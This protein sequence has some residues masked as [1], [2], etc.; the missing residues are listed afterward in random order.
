MHAHAQ[1]SCTR[2]LLKVHRRLCELKIA[3]RRFS[4][5]N[6]LVRTSVSGH[7][8]TVRCY[9]VFIIIESET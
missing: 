3:E 1:D 5:S 6:S 9:T 2:Q 4:E 8:L 7:Q